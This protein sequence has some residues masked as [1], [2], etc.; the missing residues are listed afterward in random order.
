[1][2]ERCAAHA[3][4]TRA[5]K[6]RLN[7]SRMAHLGAGHNTALWLVSNRHTES[8]DRRASARHFFGQTA[9]GVNTSYASRRNARAPDDGRP[10]SQFTRLLAMKLPPPTR[11]PVKGWPV[12]PASAPAAQAIPKFVVPVRAFRRTLELRTCMLTS[13]AAAAMYSPSSWRPA[14]RGSSSWSSSSA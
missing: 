13:S 1:M 8:D 7:E 3:G 6:L 12:A 2:P 11:L 4:S 9:G 5:V 10:P 14:D